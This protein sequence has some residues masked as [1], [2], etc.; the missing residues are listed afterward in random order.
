MRELLTYRQRMLTHWRNTVPA[1]QRAVA[2]LT[3]EIWQC[4]P[5]DGQWTPHQTLAHLRDMEQKVFQPCI[6]AFIAD[7]QHAMP[8][9][10]DDEAWLSIYRPDEPVADLLA[11]YADLRQREAEWL[12]SLPADGWIILRRHPQVGMRSLQWWIERSLATARGHLRL[13]E[14]STKTDFSGMISDNSTP[15]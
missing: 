4:A 11:T 12:D 14:Q 1:L 3:E 7:T 2:R 13:L 15:V 10:L 5:R 9:C 6:Y 8:L